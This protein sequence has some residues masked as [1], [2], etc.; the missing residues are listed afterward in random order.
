[1]TTKNDNI[2]KTAPQSKPNDGK[3]D[4]ELMKNHEL[5]GSVKEWPPEHR[6]KKQA[7]A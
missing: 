6:E 7:N 2:L 1:M 3:T 5:Y 4:Y